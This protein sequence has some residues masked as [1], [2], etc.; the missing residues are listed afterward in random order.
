MSTVPSRRLTEVEYLQL[1]RAAVTKSEFY[2]GEVFAMTGASR[3]HNL[4][5]GN[6]SRFLNEQLDDRPCEVY[7]GD[8]RVRV[9][10]TGL[11]T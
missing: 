11:Y 1:E 5:A 8:M 9:S 2:R 6:V 7:Q 10:P 4:I 3:A